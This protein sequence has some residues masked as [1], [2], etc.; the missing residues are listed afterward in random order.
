MNTSG[1]DV[2]G[3][4]CGA[5][6]FSVTA[7]PIWSAYCHCESC[8]RATA[9]PVAA[10]VG[11]DEGSVQFRGDAM[12]LFS[13]SSGVERAAV[14]TAERRCPTAATHG[15]AADIGELLDQVVS[16]STAIRDV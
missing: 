9:S 4:L 6:R 11:F 7:K 2:G 1:N 13:S 15:G 12:R 3:C 5:V 8:R 10:F 14:S 16:E